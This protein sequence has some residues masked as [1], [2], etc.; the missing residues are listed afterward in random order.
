MVGALSQGL[1]T[2]SL[3][4][5]V[6]TPHTAHSTTLPP[7]HHPHPT[8]T[9]HPTV[10]PPGQQPHPTPHIPHSAGSSAIHPLP[11]QPTTGVD[12]EGSTLI[13]PT[14]PIR[15]PGHPTPA[16]H[17]LPATPGTVH[18][19]PLS[20][21]PGAV[22]TQPLASTPG[23]STLPPVVGSTPQRR[24]AGKSDRDEVVFRNKP[25]SCVRHRLGQFKQRT[26]L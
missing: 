16:S 4:P 5:S 8:L 2:P 3:P 21:T 23:R 1:P 20:S 6:I 13:Y 17:T 19:Q 7:G 25:C 18:R 9:P 12:P 11:H 10:L 22:A 26:Y 14:S 24:A 15:H